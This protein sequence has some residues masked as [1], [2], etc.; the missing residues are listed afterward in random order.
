M[1]KEKHTYPS[2]AKPSSFSHAKLSTEASTTLPSPRTLLSRT[3]QAQFRMQVAG[4]EAVL[5]TKVEFGT[6]APICWLEKLTATCVV[7]S[8]DPWIPMLAEDDPVS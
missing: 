6:T 8:Y 5:Q 7:P 4:V 2:Y 3:P 1:E